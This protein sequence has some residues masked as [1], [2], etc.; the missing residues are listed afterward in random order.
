MTEVEEF[1]KKHGGD[2]TKIIRSPAFSD[3]MLLLN[4]KKMKELTSLNP[5]Q[6]R[7]N[8]TEILADLVGHLKHEND[9]MTLHEV[10][11]FDVTDLAEH[12]TYPDEE[13]PT[14]KKKRK[15]KD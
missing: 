1:Q 15:G 13:L 10:R 7:A 4:L 8:G 12:E 11:S 6:I 9:L 3:A 2:W 14:A 5:D